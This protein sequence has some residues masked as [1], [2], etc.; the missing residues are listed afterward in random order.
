MTTDRPSD[1]T[2]PTDVDLTDVLRTI[3][4]L[5]SLVK[6][7]RT[8][9]G[10][11]Q[12]DVAEVSGVSSGLVTRLEQGDVNLRVTTVTRLLTWLAVAVNRPTPVRIPG[13]RPPTR[14]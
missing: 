2:S 5:P 3:Y 6:E 11:T 12:R 8:R 14:G 9:L 13:R 1:D 10:L 7:T 4:A